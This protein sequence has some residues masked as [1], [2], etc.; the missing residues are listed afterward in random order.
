MEELPSPEARG[1]RAELIPACGHGGAAGRQR[2][3]PEGVGP[4]VL[5]QKQPWD[6]A[7]AHGDPFWAV[8]KGRASRYGAALEQCWESCSPWESRAGP[9]RA[10]R[11]LWSRR[12]VRGS[13]RDEALRADR[14]PVSRSSAPLGGRRQKTLDGDGVFSLFFLFTALVC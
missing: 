4:R 2:M 5:P 8:V 7:A 11:H 3:R 12:T 14:C 10:G 1:H 13:A 6:G 9:V